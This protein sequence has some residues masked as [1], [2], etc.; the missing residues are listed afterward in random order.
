MVI[1]LAFMS[2]KYKFK[3][4][5]LQSVF[6]V[7][8]VHKIYT[9][10]LI[11]VDTLQGVKASLWALSN[12]WWCFFPRELIGQWAGLSYMLY[13]LICYL[14]HNLLQ[15]RCAAWV[16]MVIYPVKKGNTILTLRIQGW[17]WSHLANPKSCIIPQ[18]SGSSENHAYVHSNHTTTYFGTVVRFSSVF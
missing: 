14:E 3:A 18:T 17:T 8:L 13:L 11:Y 16:N 9:V 12:E 2:Y 7:S 1:R 4:F 6:V 10:S 5:V 15:S